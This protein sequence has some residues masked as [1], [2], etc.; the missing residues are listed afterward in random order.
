M[1]SFGLEVIIVGLF[2]PLDG[3][4]LILVLY[5]ATENKESD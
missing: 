1:N 3:M 5:K 2:P 4:R